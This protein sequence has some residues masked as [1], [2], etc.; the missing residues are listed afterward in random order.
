MVEFPKVN[1]PASIQYIFIGHFT[2]FIPTLNALALIMS[3]LNSILFLKSMVN[4]QP[5][6]RSLGYTRYSKMGGGAGKQ[7]KKEMNLCFKAKHFWFREIYSRN[8]SH[9]VRWKRLYCKKAI[10]FTR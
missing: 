9:S 5:G 4:P 8:V 1:F 3:Y 2:T 7:S 6:G 10:C